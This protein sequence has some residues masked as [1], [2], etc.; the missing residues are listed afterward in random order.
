MVKIEAMLVAKSLE[1]LSDTDR[2]LH[3]V[4]SEV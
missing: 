2:N 1:L 4:I 3:K